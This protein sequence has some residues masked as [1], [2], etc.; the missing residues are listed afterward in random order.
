MFTKIVISIMSFVIMFATT[1][2]LKFVAPMD[3][4]EE[5]KNVII[6]IG[7]GMGFNHLY[8]TQDKYGVELQMITRTEYH[9]ESK[10]RSGSSL[11]T[12]S[13]AG[14]TALATGHRTINGYVGVYPTD[15]LSVIANPSS[16]TEVAMKY[17]KSTGIVTSDSIMGATPAGFSVHVRD[18]DLADKIFAQQVVS[19]IDLI[20]GAVAGEVT[21]AEVV[22]NGKVFVDNLSEVQAL[23]PGQKSIGQFHSDTMWRGLDNGDQPTLS[24]LAVEA[25]DLLNAD[26]DGF[27]LMLEG[28]HIDKRSHDQDGNGAMEA[29]LEFD[30]AIGKVLDFAEEDGNTLVII[31][32]DHETGFVTKQNDG[33]YKWLIGGHSG[34]NVPCFVYGSDTFIEEGE[35][36]DNIDIPTM[37][38]AYMTN[39]DQY[40]PCPIVYLEQE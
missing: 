26:E 14:A 27:F 23:E 40:F 24:E 16:I 36:I 19:D 11:V 5:I 21:E 18:R 8:A 2:G 34:A 10:T 22:E 6:M 9:G 15:P 38:V 39:N 29:V 12:D 32:A 28:A 17:G 1:F 25:L 31:T 3:E 20:W 35:A 30:K 7:D 13:A 4:A 37:A 33:S